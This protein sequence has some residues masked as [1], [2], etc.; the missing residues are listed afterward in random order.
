MFCSYRDG[1]THQSVL[2]SIS[3][4][5]GIG[6]LS[7]Y[8]DF[9]KNID[10]NLAEVDMESFRAEDIHSLLTTLPSLENK[11]RR[12]VCFIILRVCRRGGY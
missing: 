10:A 8:D 9:A 12:K 5:N 4:Y 6:E 3:S 1:V 2:S 7:Y 11:K